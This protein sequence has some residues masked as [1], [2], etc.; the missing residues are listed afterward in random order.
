M[1]VSSSPKAPFLQSHFDSNKGASLILSYWPA[2]P[3]LFDALCQAPPEPM[4]LATLNPHYKDVGEEPFKRC[5][6]PAFSRIQGKELSNKG[7]K[8]SNSGT[9]QSSVQKGQRS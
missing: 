8:H 5:G 9:E 2:C 7:P 4:A 1:S 3:P 6:G